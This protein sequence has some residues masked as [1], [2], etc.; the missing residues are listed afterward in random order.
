MA[1]DTN[2]RN[3]ASSR[4]FPPSWKDR[5]RRKK[6]EY[7]GGGTLKFATGRSGGEVGVAMDEPKTRNGGSVCR[8]CDRNASETH[9]VF[10]KNDEGQQLIQLIRECLPIVVS[11]V[12]FLAVWRLDN[13]KICRVDLQERSAV[14]GSLQRLLGSSGDV[15]QVQEGLGWGCRSTG[16]TVEERRQDQRRGFVPG[17]ARERCLGTVGAR[18]NFG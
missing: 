3:T 4:R 15:L 10:E 5:S 13:L 8:I 7:A 18:K 2:N 16:R 6:Y 12:L 9:S 1:P 14:E 17:A 11:S